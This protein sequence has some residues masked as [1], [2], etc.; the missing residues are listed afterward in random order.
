MALISCPSETSAS[1]AIE[2]ESGVLFAEKMA[3][4]NER[5]SGS[6]TLRLNSI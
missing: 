2:D 6:E 4:E 1:V 3:G 5:A